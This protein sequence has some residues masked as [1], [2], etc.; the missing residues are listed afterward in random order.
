MSE[1]TPEGEPIDTRTIWLPFADG[2]V[3]ITADLTRFNAAMRKVDDAFLRYRSVDGRPTLWNDVF[4]TDPCSWPRFVLFP[5]LERARIAAQDAR[6]RVRDAW[7]VLRGRDGTQGEW[8][9]A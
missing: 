2:E 9:D 4:F 6:T 7:S 8:E 5:R 1:L 3:A